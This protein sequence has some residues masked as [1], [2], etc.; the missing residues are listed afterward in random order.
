M[1]QAEDI[2]RNA[3]VAVLRSPGDHSHDFIE[4]VSR[5]AGLHVKLFTDRAKALAHL[6]EE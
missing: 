2:D 6:L 3:R 4:T 1:Q 5:N